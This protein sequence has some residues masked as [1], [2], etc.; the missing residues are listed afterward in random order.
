MSIDTL[1]RWVKT[2]LSRSGINISEF[3]SHSTRHASTSTAKRNGVGIDVIRAT[4]E[5][6]K[7]SQVFAKFYNLPLMEEHSTFA[8]A[9]LKS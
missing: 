4:A 1:S 9:V 7:D 6:S 3:S 8:N 5:W 2:L